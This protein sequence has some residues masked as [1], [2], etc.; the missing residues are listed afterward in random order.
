MFVFNEQKG[1]RVKH[2]KREYSEGKVSPYEK[3]GK[4]YWRATITE[5]VITEATDDMGHAIVQKNG[6]PKLERRRHL[7]NRQFDIPCSK[8][9]DPDGKTKYR[10]VKKADKAFKEWRESLIAKADKDYE[11]AI[12]NDEADARADEHN[13]GAMF[14][15]KFLDLYLKERE[16]AS[17]DDSENR[18]EKSTLSGYRYA[19]TYASRYFADVPVGE[20][21]TK[22]LKAFNRWLTN[23]RLSSTTR[24]RAIKMLKFAW[25]AHKDEIS[26]Y[27]FTG[28]KMP[29]P[30]EARPNPLTEQSVRKVALDIKESPANQFMTAVAL[31]LATAMRVGEV[32]GLK[33]SSVNM[34]TGEIVVENAIGRAEGGTKEYEKKPKFTGKDKDHNSDRTIPG[35]PT[36]PAILRRRFA[37]MV[38]E[39]KGCH[40]GVSDKE[41]REAVSGMYVIGSVDGRY[42]SPTVIGRTWR[43]YSQGLMGECGR[44]PTFHDLRDTKL[45]DLARHV[46]NPK[47]LSEIAGNSPAVAYTN[48]IAARNKDKEK[49]MVDSDG[50]LDLD[51]GE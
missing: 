1:E 40:D 51:W 29:Q 34:E 19:M 4:L 10:N 31:S 21:T 24:N 48:Y 37:Y 11:L 16:N 49:A 2:Y 25:D 42:A 12:A 30:R 27:P 22:S 20:V 5:Y 32:C 39:Y 36:I 38:D 9:K 45:T 41:A 8:Y 18:L 3:R 13:Y 14:V 7:L 6:E 50:L 47:V 17:E 26:G 46:K 44:R 15:P 23:K 43:G 33:W 35:A 28:F